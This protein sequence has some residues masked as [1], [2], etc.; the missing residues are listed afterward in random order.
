MVFNLRVT[1]VTGKCNDKDM[2]AFIKWKIRIFGLF[3]KGHERTEA[4]IVGGQQSA[5]RWE[6]DPAG[7]PPSPAEPEEE[8][9]DTTVGYQ[10]ED[11]TMGLASPTRIQNGVM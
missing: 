9:E 1:S 4:K 6:P 5:A 7:P 2:L 10:E 8:E 11:T 3:Q